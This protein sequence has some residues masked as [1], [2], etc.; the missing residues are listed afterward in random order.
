M[1]GEVIY[2][3]S[4][5]CRVDYFPGAIFLVSPLKKHIYCVAIKLQFWWWKSL[6]LTWQGELHIQAPSPYSQQKQ[7]NVSD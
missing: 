3:I 6:F 7:E 4:A 5:E 2:T 1:S